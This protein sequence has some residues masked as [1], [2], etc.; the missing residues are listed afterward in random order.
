MDE[1]KY[2]GKILNLNE[3]L[4]QY[5]IEIPI[6]QRDYAQG[7]VD[8]Q[9]IRDNFL[10]ALHHSIDSEKAIKLDFIYGSVQDDVFLPL[11]GQQRLTTLF[12]LYWYASKKDNIKESIKLLSKFS[13]ETR[14]SSRDFCKTLVANQFVINKDSD[15][16]SDI[17]DSSWFFLSWKKDPT[18]DAMLRSI[19]AIHKLFYDIDNLWTKLTSNANLISFYHVEL[20]NIGLTDDLYIKMNARGKL[21]SNFEN[22]KAGFQKRINENEWDKNKTF[23]DTFAL[24]IDTLWTD[25]F[26]THRLNDRIDDAIIRFISSILMIRQSTE[27]KDD[28]LLNISAIQDNPNNIKPSLFNESDYIY[29]SKCLDIYYKY[30]EKQIN[31]N[32]VIPLFQHKSHDNIFSAIVAE[33]RNSSYSQKVL[34]YA[35]TEYLLNVDEFDF[36]YFQDWMRV[37]RNII[38]RGD[39]AKTG[40]RPI[41]TRS[42]SSFDGIIGLIQELSLGCNDIY[43]HLASLTTLNSS[44]AKD[45]IEEER[46]KAKLLVSQPESRTEIFRTESFSLLQGRIEFAFFCIDSKN[47]S[48]FN[49]EKLKSFNDVFEEYFNDDTSINNDFRRAMLT[50]SDNNDNY[51]YYGYWWSFWNVVSANKRCLIDKF[52]ELEFYIYG[53][54][55]NK[56]NYRVF[57]KKLIIKLFNEDMKSIVDNFNPPADMPNWQI[58][59]IKENALLDDKSKSNYIAIPDDK[60]CCYLLKSVRPRDLDG[61]ERIV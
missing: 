49:L 9:E 16:R 8:K 32:L 37:V 41:I 28:R 53:K 39:I 61:C 29:L 25:I 58:R 48:D 1:I 46:R 26:W 47:E 18:I 10:N 20:E 50:I 3:L 4:E 57:F 51:N 12:L 30:F 22:F 55:K 5:R 43:S 7:R 35:Q 52:R 6:I 40:H 23:R 44:F 15:L 14:I 34:L 24:K 56:N 2:E 38:C 17:I 36:S 42:P 54:Y 21:L 45:Q 27:K 11:D 31:I 60:S 59:L 33:G 13:Y 19:D